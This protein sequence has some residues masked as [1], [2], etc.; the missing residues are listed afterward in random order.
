MILP[1][2]IVAILPEKAMLIALALLV[3]SSMAIF[4]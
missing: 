2:K 4:R 1:T 3:L